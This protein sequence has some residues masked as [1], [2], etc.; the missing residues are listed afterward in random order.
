MLPPPSLTEVIL[1]IAALVTKRPWSSHKGSIYKTYKEGKGICFSGVT[2][3][4][5]KPVRT[6]SGV[7]GKQKFKQLFNEVL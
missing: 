7:H 1:N 3:L 6:T 5:T 2:Q 4:Q